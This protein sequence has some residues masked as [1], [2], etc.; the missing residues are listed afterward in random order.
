MANVIIIVVNL[1]QQYKT[2]M[3]IFT[4]HPDA[5]CEA[6]HCRTEVP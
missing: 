2:E 1:V 4:A 5:F 3:F 6:E